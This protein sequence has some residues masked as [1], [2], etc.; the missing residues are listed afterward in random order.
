[1]LF[2]LYDI[3]SNHALPGILLAF[4]P[5]FLFLSIPNKKALKNYSLARKIMG[6]SYLILSLALFA[7]SAS[8]QRPNDI[9]PQRMQIIATGCVQL[10]LFTYSL[11]TLIDTGF[12]TKRKI[13]REIFLMVSASGASLASFAL[14]SEMFS[15]AV[16][17]ILTVWYVSLAV[18][19]VVIFRKYYRHYRKHVDNYFSD[20]EC[21][22]LH[23]V[24]R[25]FYGIIGMGILALAFT[26]HITPVTHLVYM[27]VADVFYVAFAIF[28]LNYVS[29]FPQLETPMQ[30]IAA[31]S[32]GESDGEEYSA[33]SVTEQDTEEQALILEIDKIMSD[34]KP[35]LCSDLNVEKLASLTGK[36][37]RLVSSSINHCRGTN[38]NTYINGYRVAEAQ[39]L[40]ESGWLEEHTMDA[41]AE[42]T[43]FGNRINLYRVF[44]RFKGVSPSSF[45]GQMTV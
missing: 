7:Q 35:Y 38:F 14:D 9:L 2:F 10:F 8:H 45:S 3:L 21:N 16:F 37:R 33:D 43:G 18:R 39:R 44:K 4:G 24:P 25:V 22:R 27:V 28:F 41:L 11:I 20:D 31:S 42:S 29:I 1:M 5:C 15:T 19:Y 36:S 23:W 30:E 6:T 34:E 17:Y 26:W 40:I 13:W 32:T 12:L